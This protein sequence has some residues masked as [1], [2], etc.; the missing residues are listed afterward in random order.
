MMSD[1]LGR[2]QMSGVVS[3]SKPRVYDIKV[4]LLVPFLLDYLWLRLSVYSDFTGG[5]TWP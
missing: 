2:K 3:L 5:N 1:C 4:N